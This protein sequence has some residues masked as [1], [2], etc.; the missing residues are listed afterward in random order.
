LTVFLL[1]VGDTILVL[2]VPIL[3]ALAADVDAFVRGAFTA[4]YSCVLDTNRGLPPLRF[5]GLLE[6]LSTKLPLF[7]FFTAHSEPHLAS[8]L[9]KH[10]L[11]NEFVT[12]PLAFF[13]VLVT[14][15]FI[16]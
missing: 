10:I 5:F 14:A 11:V 1:G 3:V 12:P 7:R 4:S 15:L 8:F 6:L 16:K 2:L 9:Q 13:S